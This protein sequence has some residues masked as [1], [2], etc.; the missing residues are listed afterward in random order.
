MGKKLAVALGLLLLLLGGAFWVNQQLRENPGST[1]EPD[2]LI[3]RTQTDTEEESSPQ[4]VGSPRPN[5]EPARVE[6]PTPPVGARS[7]KGVVVD[8]HGT[9]VPQAIVLLNPYAERDPLARSLPS[10]GELQVTTESDGRF[11]ISTDVRRASLRAR[12]PGWIQ[13]EGVW[14]TGDKDVRIVLQRSVPVRIRVRASE[15]GRPLAGARVRVVRLAAM[16]PLPAPILTEATTGADGFA[17]LDSAPGKVSFIAD[18]PGRASA[19]LWDVNVVSP[20]STWTLDLGVGGGVRGSVVD[21]AGKAVPGA[22]IVLL[23]FP[24]VRMEQE[25]DAQG[26]FQFL[27]VPSASPQPEDLMVAQRV[28]VLMCDT[29]EFGR[30]FLEVDPP[31]ESNTVEV[32]FALGARHAVEGYVHYTDQ[33]PAA[34]IAVG[35]ARV[36]GR[37]EWGYISFHTEPPV[38]TDETGRFVLPNLPT[39][40]V[41]IRVPDTGSGEFTHVVDVPSTAPVEIVLE[42]KAET[43][44]VRVLYADGTAA[45]GA[46]VRVVEWPRGYTQRNTIVRTDADGVANV[47][48]PDE[49]SFTLDVR[50]RDAGPGLFTYEQIPSARELVV[51]LGGGVVAGRLLRLDGSPVVGAPISL[52]RRL[53]MTSGSTTYV[54]EVSGSRGGTT[55]GE[56]GAFE[57]RGISDG[58]HVP[59]ISWSSW[60]ILEDQD[61]IRPGDA[62]VVLHALTS[63]E[64]A[65]LSPVVDV[66]IDGG[67]PLPVDVQLAVQ[68]T[69]TNED[70]GTEVGLWRNPDGAYHGRPLRPGVW[71][72][73]ARAPGYEPAETRVRYAADGPPVRPQLA[74]RP[75]R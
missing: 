74:L 24:R 66:Q 27:G 33:A 38:M 69:A 13:M 42:V 7:I 64:V 56:D 21:P 51:R 37:R 16:L 23:R 12:A 72:L 47:Q 48:L 46:E 57:L 4:L 53:Q 26:R 15:S 54:T 32:Q 11:E 43:R 20:E 39:G 25:T 14:P 49:G 9:P 61:V 52:S 34:G 19:A 17:D 63:V 41:G 35:Y 75:S 3:A 8:E 50:P 65:A 44:P 70:T 6:A 10:A 55:T 22:R 5:D 29:A 40:R 68:V 60:A 31:L 36:E 62:P 1:R 45:A 59:R 58:P 71:I 67:G 28:V 18:A 30:Q 73:R 2:P